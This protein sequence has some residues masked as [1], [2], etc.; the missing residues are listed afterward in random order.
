MGRA[1]WLG[2][3]CCALVILSGCGGGGGHPTYA[4]RG[5][6]V[7]A[8]YRSI[9]RHV[10]VPPAD[11]TDPAQGAYLARVVLDARQELAQLQA[12]GPPA[13]D[14]R[15]YLAQSGAQLRLIAAGAHQL[16]LSNTAAAESE[17]RS[18]SL[19]SGRIAALAKRYGFKVCS[20]QFSYG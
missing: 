17:L 2:A 3:V 7:C 1:F 8:T 20:S 4:T 12:L 9:A 5:D 6:R 15:A 13:G 14:A 10:K 18:A 16:T 19:L 11:A